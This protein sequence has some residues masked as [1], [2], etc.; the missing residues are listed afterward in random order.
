MRL[1]GNV[2]NGL[3]VLLLP[4]R[5]D[6]LGQVT[7]DGKVTATASGAEGPMQ[8]IFTGQISSKFFGRTLCGHL[9]DGR[10]N[11]DITLYRPQ[12]H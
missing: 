12:S 8:G 1:Y 11:P 3:F 2:F 4:G 10:C 9:Q 5:V 7:P 6:L